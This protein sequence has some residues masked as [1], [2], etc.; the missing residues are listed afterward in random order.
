MIRGSIVPWY[1]IPV[2]G[3]NRL[4]FRA[5]ATSAPTGGFGETAYRVPPN[6]ARCVERSQSISIAE[7]EPEAA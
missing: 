2:S 6:G 3:L 7:P 5:Q 1:L 4:S